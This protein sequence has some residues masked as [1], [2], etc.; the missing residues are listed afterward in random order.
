MCF[1]KAAIIILCIILSFVCIQNTVAQENMKMSSAIQKLRE[2][3][4]DLTDSVLEIIGNELNKDVN[5]LPLTDLLMCL[6]L[7]NYDYD[8]GDWSPR[9][10]CVYAFD[11]EIYDIERMYTLFLQG[12]QSIVPD[13]TISDIHED[14]SEM[15]EEMTE[16][17]DDMLPPSDGK[18]SVSFLCN[19]HPY[20]ITLDS[21][22]DWFNEEMFYFMDQVLEQE[23]C[24]RKLFEFTA[25]AQ[26]MIVVYS[27]DDVARTLAPFIAEF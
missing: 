18:R 11:A 3:G 22:G 20:S 19:G 2:L 1:N 7:G 23:N 13:I 14:V 21:Y 12:I 16:S 26:Y 15:T 4:F 9:S 8:T 6:G 17:K 25:Y 27:T 5:S 10:K 24:P